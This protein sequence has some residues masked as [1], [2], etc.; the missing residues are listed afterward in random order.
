MMNSLGLIVFF[1]IYLTVAFEPRNLLRMCELEIMG[2]SGLLRPRKVHVA[3]RRQEMRQDSA[4]LPQ[5]ARPSDS[6][7]ALQIQQTTSG[8]LVMMSIHRRA[9]RY[10]KALKLSDEA[11]SLCNSLGCPRSTCKCLHVM[12]TQIVSSFPLFRRLQ[13]Y[14]IGRARWSK[15]SSRQEDATAKQK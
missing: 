8:A 14:D 4:H 1:F 3:A 5:R 13:A 10:A 9:T 15:T 6:F 12:S 7:I 11:S 2:T